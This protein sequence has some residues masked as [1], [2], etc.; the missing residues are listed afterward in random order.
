M[1]DGWFDS[2][3]GGYIATNTLGG[4]GMNRRKKPTHSIEVTDHFA[5]DILTGGWH[6]QAPSKATKLF[7]E[8]CAQK[9][10]Y[11]TGNVDGACK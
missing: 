4:I 11:R 8:H 3:P 2:I 9:K 6:S 1:F 5:T 10:M 7:R